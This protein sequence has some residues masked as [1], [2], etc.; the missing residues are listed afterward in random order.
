MEEKLE[1]VSGMN[2]TDMADFDLYSGPPALAATVEQQR[3]F[4]P[5]SKGKV[6]NRPQP[7]HQEDQ[8]E[9]QIRKSCPT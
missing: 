8:T 2:F 5:H 9:A 6:I 7:G 1:C 4:E 3:S